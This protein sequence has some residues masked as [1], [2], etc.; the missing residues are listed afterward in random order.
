M[1]NNAPHQSTI[2]MKMAEIA[3]QARSKEANKTNAA[4]LI[5]S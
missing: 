5:A 1:P 3:N 2:Q 4:L